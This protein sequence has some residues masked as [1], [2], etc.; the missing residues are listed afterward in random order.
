[1][2]RH[3]ISLSAA[4][5]LAAPYA[6]HAQ[7]PAPSVPDNI[8]V[9]SGNAAFLVG[10]AI[11]TQNYEC[12]P[13]SSLG[14][15]G[16]VLFTPQATLFDGQNQQLTTHFFSP[17]PSETF[18][19]RPAWQHSED[20][21]TVWGRGRASSAD[22]TFVEPGAIPW[23]LIERAGTRPGPTGGTA[24]TVTTFIQRVNTEGGAAPTEGCERPPDIGSRAFV[25][26][27]ADYYFYRQ[28]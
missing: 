2:K 16:W 5:A 9:P 13:V 26:Y 22:P 28:Q 25:P 18:T 20:T 10:H 17:N 4:L 7:I 1:M 19:I 3:V 12:Q 27:E 11:G 8:K 21:S 23:L 14:R 24:L 6:A 15:P